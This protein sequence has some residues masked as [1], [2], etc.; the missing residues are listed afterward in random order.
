MNHWGIGRQLRSDIASFLHKKTPLLRILLV[1]LF[2][3]TI[4][5]PLV[6]AKPLSVSQPH[7]ISTY[8]AAA[9]CQ[10]CSLDAVHYLGACYLN[11][12]WLLKEEV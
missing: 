7:V 10:A 2:W 11:L 3:K 1:P 9:V 4:S 8:I 5:V 12:K 6:T